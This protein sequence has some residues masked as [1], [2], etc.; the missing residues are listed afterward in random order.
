VSTNGHSGTPAHKSLLPHGIGRTTGKLHTIG[1]PSA[2]DSSRP[3]TGQACEAG[4]LRLPW[5]TAE[6]HYTRTR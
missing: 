2:L 1:T 5:D 6:T 3:L 4:A